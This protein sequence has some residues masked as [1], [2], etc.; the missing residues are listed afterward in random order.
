MCKGR[1][2]SST[3]RKKLVSLARRGDGQTVAG[4]EA[5]VGLCPAVDAM[6]GI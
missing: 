2:A 6:L 4:K 3:N 1:K 5:T